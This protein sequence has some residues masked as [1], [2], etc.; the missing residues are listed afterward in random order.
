L[1]E[2]THPMQANWNSK[3]REGEMPYWF[4]SPRTVSRCR[5]SSSSICRIAALAEG[6]RT[7][8]AWPT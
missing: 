1:K 8:F 3:Y 7:E 2:S 4:I 6:S 5:H